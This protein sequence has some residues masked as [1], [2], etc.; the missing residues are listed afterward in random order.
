MSTASIDLCDEMKIKEITF[1]LNP[2]G[3]W[4][5]FDNN[6]SSIVNQVWNEVKFLDDNENLNIEMSTI[7]DDHGGIYIFILKPNIIPQLH[8]YIL[9]IGR[10]K[11]TSNQNLRKRCREYFKDSR[12]KVHRM[13]TKWGKYLYIRYLPLSDNTTIEKLEEEL[14]NAIIPPCNDAQPNAQLRY[15]KKSAF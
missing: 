15:A 9:Y 2:G 12:S 7:P 11:C 13:R 3:V 8:Q 4:E 1:H 10:A 6:L 5:Q 14:I